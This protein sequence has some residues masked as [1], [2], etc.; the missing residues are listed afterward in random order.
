MKNLKIT[1]AT[2]MLATVLSASS[3]KGPEKT[4]EAAIENQ[5]ETSS[6]EIATPETP[7]AGAPESV[8]AGKVEETSDDHSKEKKEKADGASAHKAEE[9][10]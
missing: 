10:K 9:K 2:L 3:C 1:L 6:N 4:E 8:E 5:E 7:A